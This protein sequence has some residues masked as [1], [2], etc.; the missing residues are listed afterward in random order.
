[1]GV[2]AAFAIGLIFACATVEGVVA[3]VRGT[4]AGGCLTHFVVSVAGGGGV[5]PIGGSFQSL[6]VADSPEEAY[7]PECVE[8]KFSEVRGSKRLL[9]AV[10][11]PWQ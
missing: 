6:R 5:S 4:C 1:M 8:E 7:S 2:I 10:A 9:Y 11:G 3:W